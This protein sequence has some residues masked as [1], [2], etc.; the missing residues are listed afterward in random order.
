M[1]KLPT[2]L[3]TRPD[4]AGSDLCSYL[5][6]QGIKTIHFPTIAFAPPDQA[7]KLPLPIENYD[8]LIFVS[9]QSVY[10][11]AAKLSGT[12]LSSRT[13]I[14]AIGAGTAQALAKYSLP[15]A[16]YPSDWNSEGL[17][18]LPAFK[19]IKDFNIA[20]V[21]GAGGRELLYPSLIERG[22]HVTNLYVYQRVL[23]KVAPETCLKIVKDQP[24][25]AIVCTSFEGVRN[26]KL[27]AG[28]LGW[29]YI[30]SKPF[31][32]PSERIKALA[33][34]LNFQSIRTSLNASHA[35]IWDCFMKINAKK[36]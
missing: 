4:P 28:D 31:I 2:M 18:N 16:I 21:A 20:I 5:A 3:I 30:Q 27:L 14:A 35:A 17:L 24:I 6:T 11:Y 26:L 12:P 22:A 1:K 32:V 34:D 19:R 7:P 9:P 33:Q 10:A 29:P 13:K 23:P 8:W 15:P 25:D 36:D